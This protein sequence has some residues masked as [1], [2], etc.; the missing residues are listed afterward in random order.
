MVEAYTHPKKAG[1]DREV[2]ESAFMQFY[3]M[4]FMLGV[5]VTVAFIRGVI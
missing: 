1:L 2:E 5:L 4:V 3:Q